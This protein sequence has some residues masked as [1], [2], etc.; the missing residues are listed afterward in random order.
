MT[1]IAS[2][3]QT[4]IANRR[5]KLRRARQIKLAQAVWRSLFVGSLS[6]SLVWI[7][8]LP[9]W[10]ISQ[11]EQIA[12]EGNKLLSPEAIRSLLTFSYPQS[13]LRVEPHKLAS[14]LESQVPIAEAT[15][16]RQLLPPGL[17]I[18]VK[19]RLPVAVTQLSSNLN[20]KTVDPTSSL[21]LLDEKGQWMPA[22]SYQTLEPNL[23]LP[24]LK[25]IGLENHYQSYWSEVYPV[26]ERSKVKVFELDWQ[27]PA[28]LIIKTELGQAHLGPYSSQFSEQLA[29]LARMRDLPSHIKPS[30]IAYIDL[31]NPELPAIQ[32]KKGNEAVQPS[33]H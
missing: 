11:P 27:N 1:N 32:I 23:K 6:C 22:S 9:D 7:I 28:N 5:K 4:Q 10:V 14:S 19:E 12:V 33:T 24:T 17:T 26:L 29:I 15:V 13:L 25:V 31:K 21:G 18:Q 20:S 30:Q 2:V 3:S 16:S 8:T